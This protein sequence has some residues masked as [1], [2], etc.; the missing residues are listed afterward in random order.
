MFNIYLKMVSQG[1][2]I[3]L[4]HSR[5]YEYYKYMTFLLK[6]EYFT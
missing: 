6:N 4:S 3:F 2:I 1:G 5:C